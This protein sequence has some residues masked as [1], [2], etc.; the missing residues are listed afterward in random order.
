MRARVSTR[1][2]L[3]RVER[4]VRTAT[5]TNLRPAV[6][7]SATAATPTGIQQM[8]AKSRCLRSFNWDRISRPIV[9]CPAMTSG[10]SNG[11]TTV[12][13]LVTASRS[14]APE[15]K[16]KHTNQPRRV[17]EPVR[18]ER[19]TKRAKCPVLARRLL[20]RG[21]RGRR[22]VGNCRRKRRI[23]RSAS[24]HGRPTARVSF[25]GGVRTT[26][27]TLRP[28]QSA[29]RHDARR[30]RPAPLFSA[31]AMWA[32]PWERPAQH[33]PFFRRQPTLTSMI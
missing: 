32:C 7:C 4:T 19:P 33:P 13:P 14:A 1:R 30:A 22:A 25:G 2:V 29:S 18:A 17:R 20:A 24:P 10:S 21:P 23:G 26:Y 27:H 15:Q 28:H 3:P 31:A 5:A 6:A 12:C 16:S 9:P 8:G 11:W